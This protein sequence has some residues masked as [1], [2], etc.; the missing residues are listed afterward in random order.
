MTRE[1]GDAGCR[2]HTDLCTAQRLAERALVYTRAPRGAAGQ[3]LGWGGVP[4]AVT[5]RGRTRAAGGARKKSTEREAA[6]R[7]RIGVAQLQRGENSRS[8][9]RWRT[10]TRRRPRCI[11]RRRGDGYAAAEGRGAVGERVG[12]Q[13][14][15]NA[16]GTAGD[17]GGAQRRPAATG[18]CRFEEREAGTA[19]TRVH[20]RQPRRR[21]S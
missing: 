3:P 16:N 5:A 21:S 14:G 1:R 8:A 2:Y 11:L 9:A 19:K 12:A 20:A 10:A 15:G 6:Q 13:G 18:R 4:H 7:A 17:E